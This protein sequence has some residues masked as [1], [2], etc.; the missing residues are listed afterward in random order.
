MANRSLKNRNSRCAGADDLTRF[1]A[2]VLEPMRQV[3]RKVVRLARLQHTRD[4]GNRKLNATLHDDATLFAPVSEHLIARFRPRRIP[5]MEQRELTPRPL[6]RDEPERYLIVA[7]LRELLRGEK[8]LRSGGHVQG[9]E[10]GE[11]HRHAV[12]DFLQRAHRGTD[13]VLLDQRDQ[14]VGHP[15][16][17]RKCPLR[18]AEGDPDA[19]Q[20]RAYVN[21]HGC[22]ES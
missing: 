1:T 14:P 7:Q 4:A 20:S 6:S 15:R 21:A 12:E 5:L 13:T 10:L 8:R 19:A 2:N 16:P 17:P 22:S 3:A 9:K 11:G 18:K